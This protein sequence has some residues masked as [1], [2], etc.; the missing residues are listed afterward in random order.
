MLHIGWEVG[1]FCES[2]IYKN[3]LKRKAILT[4]K[5]I[6]IK[7]SDS[8]VKVKIF[9]FETESFVVRV[10]NIESQKYAE[11]IQLQ[12]YTTTNT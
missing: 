10:L 7:F 11:P 9:F 2:Y 3:N 1:I 8:C 5:F 12:L 6:L 4:N